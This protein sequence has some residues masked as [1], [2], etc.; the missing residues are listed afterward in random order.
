[1]NSHLRLLISTVEISK[2]NNANDSNNDATSE[3]QVSDYR[4]ELESHANMQ[5][6]GQ[7][8][9][10]LSDSGTFVEVN[11]FSPDYE[12]KN[13]PIV[14]AGVQYDCPHSMM[15]Y[16][17]VIRNALHVTSKTNNLIPPLM[18]QEAEI[19]VYGTPKI[20]MENPMVKDHFIYFQETGLR[21]PL[22]LWGVLSYF[23]T[24]KPTYEDMTDSEEV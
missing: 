5:V 10:I 17:L 15:T 20:Q 1:M 21:I 11:A 8:C 24:P 19:M 23:L 22:Q 3:T 2:I 9:Y 12:T 6:V 4:T 13:I 16:I 14:D 18:M 7:S